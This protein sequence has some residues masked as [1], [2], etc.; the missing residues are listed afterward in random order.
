MVSASDVITW[1]EFLIMGL[2]SI[3]V[4]EIAIQPMLVW[5]DP[6]FADDMI[7]IPGRSSNSPA[8]FAMFFSFLIIFF[9]EFLTVGSWI[10]SY[11]PDRFDY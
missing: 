10:R 6:M 4:F 2:I 11:L 1:I 7:S 9:I 3:V 8:Q 5:I